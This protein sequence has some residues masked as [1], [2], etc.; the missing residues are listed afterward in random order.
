MHWTLPFIKGINYLILL[1][2]LIIISLSSH[3]PSLLTRYFTNICKTDETNV[4]CVC[5]KRISSQMGLSISYWG[6][7]KG[8]ASH[9]W[10]SSTIGRAIL[11]VDPSSSLSLPLPFSPL[12]LTHHIFLNHFLLFSLFFLLGMIYR[13]REMLSW[14]LDPSSRYFLPPYR[15]LPS[16]LPPPRSL[17][18]PPL[19]S[20]LFRLS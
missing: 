1:L 12:I 17:S 4:T 18:S 8:L 7:L 5:Y 19:P 13:A 9:L 3:S 14:D 20:Y 6:N 2:S 10:Q 16:A 15:F 11:L